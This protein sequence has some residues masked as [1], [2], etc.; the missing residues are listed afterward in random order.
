MPSKQQRELFTTLRSTFSVL[1][2]WKALTKYQDFDA[3]S[4][5]EAMHYLGVL[6]AAFPDIRIASLCICGKPFH[7]Y[8]FAKSPTGDQS[9]PSANP[10]S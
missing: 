7:E 10:R 8:A 4:D 2:C 6:L 3:M 9:G 1:G 5:H